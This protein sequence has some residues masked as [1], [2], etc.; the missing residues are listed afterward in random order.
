MI[1]YL[2]FK[3][4]SCNI[5]RDKGFG[6]NKEPIFDFLEPEN[7]IVDMLH[8]FLRVSDRLFLMLY[9][10]ITQMDS[11]WNRRGNNNLFL[12]DP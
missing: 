12:S 4:Y 1:F 10:D 5:G 7:I 3:I 11:A 6:Y 2:I 8:L 9:Q